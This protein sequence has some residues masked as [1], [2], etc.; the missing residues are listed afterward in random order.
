MGALETIDETQ[1]AKEAAS[2]F[3]RRRQRPNESEDDRQKAL[4][5]HL[6]SRGFAGHLVRKVLD[7]L[8]SEIEVAEEAFEVDDLDLEPEAEGRSG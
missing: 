5:R 1:A 4:L 8:G 3:L 7:E 2:R 6:A